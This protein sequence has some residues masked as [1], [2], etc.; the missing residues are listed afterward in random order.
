MFDLLEKILQ[1]EARG[2]WRDW[3]EL[4]CSK[5]PWRTYRKTLRKSD[6]KKILKTME[7]PEC[8]AELKL[9][10]SIEE[11]S[12]DFPRE[13]LD[14]AI[15]D[16][17]DDSY[18]LRVDVKERILA[19][20]EEYPDAPLVEIAEEIRVVGSLGTNQYL[21]SADLDIHIVP[22]NVDEWDEE[23]ANKVIRWFNE[24]RD[25]IDCAC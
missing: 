22:K 12:I 10:E 21:D 13:G 14:L 1:V 20:L 19:I 5:C 4:R 6:P 3:S 15:W 18:T 7:C 11:S 17:E 25:E 16:K 9:E 2:H 23:G 8:G 24:N